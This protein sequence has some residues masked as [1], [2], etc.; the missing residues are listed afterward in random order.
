MKQIFFVLSFFLLSGAVSAQY[1]SLIPTPL[2]WNPS[3]SVDSSIIAVRFYIAGNTT[4]QPIGS[5]GYWDLYGNAVTI[6]GGELHSGFCSG[7]TMI[8][9][10]VLPPDCEVTRALDHFDLTTGTTTFNAD[11]YYSVAMSV[12]T[13]TASVTINSKTYSYPA[14]LNVRI[15]SPHQC[16]YLPDEIEIEVTSGRVIVETMQ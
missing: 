10:P 6:T 3:P 16:E 9:V 11:T 14:G 1:Y 4:T 2:C 7:D 5:T 13:G 12:I 15:Y 8:V